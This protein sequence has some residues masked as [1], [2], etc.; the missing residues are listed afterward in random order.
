MK[1][2]THFFKKYEVEIWPKIKKHFRNKSFL[3]LNKRVG[4]Y[5]AAT[6]IGMQ[7]KGKVYKGVAHGRRTF[8]STK[9]FEKEN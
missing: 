5:K 9:I 7:I 1:K 6:S 2:Y 3:I 8:F 4:T